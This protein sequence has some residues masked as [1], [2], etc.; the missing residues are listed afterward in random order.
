MYAQSEAVSRITA[1]LVLAVGFFGA[2]GSR[3]GGLENPATSACT[4]E[5]RRIAANAPTFSETEVDEPTRMV[6][7]NPR[8]RPSDA[9]LEA[10]RPQSAVLVFVVDTAGRI[11]PCTVEVRAAT[12][13]DFR[14][15]ILAVVPRLRFTPARRG[16][17]LVRQRASM[18]WEWRPGS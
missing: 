15:A 7:G 18:P 6:P 10:W 3:R 14:D 12:H 2:C 17:Q 8:L 9:M 1:V 16:G 11:D 5:L 4:P 13:P